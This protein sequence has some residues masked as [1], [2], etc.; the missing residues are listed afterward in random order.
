MQVK[1]AIL[2][3]ILAFLVLHIQPF[4][5]RLYQLIR[6]TVYAIEGEFH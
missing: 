2:D 4:Q 5:L 3:V 1:L 6:I